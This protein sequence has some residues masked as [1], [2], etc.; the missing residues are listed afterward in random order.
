MARGD[1]GGSPL[2]A[3]DSGVVD[4]LGGGGVELR[5]PRMNVPYTKR[6]CVTTRNDG[7]ININIGR[8][9]DTGSPL[10]F[11]TIY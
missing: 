5:G 6:K 3:E 9:S 10:I 2:G 8:N 4:G 7:V 1:H 11:V